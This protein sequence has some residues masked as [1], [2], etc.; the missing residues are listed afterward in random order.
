MQAIGGEKQIQIIAE[1]LY[2]QNLT[3]KEKSFSPEVLEDLNHLKN[4]FNLNNKVSYVLQQYLVK[5]NTKSPL[6]IPH[7]QHTGYE[8]AYINSD[9]DDYLQVT[10]TPAFISKAQAKQQQFDKSYSH[11][12]DSDADQEELAD[13]CGIP[14]D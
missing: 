2:Y 3:N 10:E 5:G 1:L 4:S 7:Y 13:A 9:G 12:Q 8:V 11:H 14:A 6:V